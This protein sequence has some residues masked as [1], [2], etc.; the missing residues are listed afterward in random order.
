MNK[1]QRQL[2]SITMIIH[3][4]YLIRLYTYVVMCI[5]RQIYLVIF[6]VNAQIVTSMFPRDWWLLQHKIVTISG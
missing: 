4:V 6:D 1:Y 3:C 5:L 2:H